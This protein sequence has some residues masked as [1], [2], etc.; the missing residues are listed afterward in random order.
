MPVLLH[1]QMA[2]APDHDQVRL[3][4]SD[5]HSVEVLLRS[6]LQSAPPQGYASVWFCNGHLPVIE[7]PASYASD[8]E[9]PY[10]E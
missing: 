2:Y 10:S 9:T 5:P 8:D 4:L 1:D 7:I 6:F 3:P